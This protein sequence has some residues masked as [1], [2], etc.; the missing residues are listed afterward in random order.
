MSRNRQ[1]K[2]RLPIGESSSDEERK[3]FT[4]KEEQIEDEEETRVLVPARGRCR[5]TEIRAVV[6]GPLLLSHFTHNYPRKNR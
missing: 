4:T 6:D 3:D 1:G 5:G 2:R